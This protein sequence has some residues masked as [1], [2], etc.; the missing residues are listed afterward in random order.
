[1][2]LLFSLVDELLSYL[3][4]ELGVLLEPFHPDLSHPL[5]HLGVNLPSLESVFPHSLGGVLGVPR[6]QLGTLAHLAIGG[7]GH[8]YKHLRSGRFLHASKCILHLTGLNIE[9]RRPRGEEG[10]NSGPS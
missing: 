3:L 4:R 8:Y 2:V 6:P 10:E 5:G 7:S 1:M 9:E